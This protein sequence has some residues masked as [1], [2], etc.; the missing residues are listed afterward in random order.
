MTALQG[1]GRGQQ[2]VGV[3]RGLVEVRVDAHDEVEPLHGRVEAAAVGRG[4]DRVSRDGDQGAH[5][6]LA[7]RVDLL[8]QADDRQLAQRLGQGAH[9]AGVA[10]EPQGPPHS[11]LATCV[12]RA[13]GRVGEHD[14]AGAVE[15]ARE[16]VDDVDQP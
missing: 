5:L 10:N 11:G 1:G 8:G 12:A 2:H 4:Q 7:G 15:V 3:A 9:A 14:A 6:A 16:R 13:V